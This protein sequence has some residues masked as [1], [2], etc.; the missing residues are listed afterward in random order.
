MICISQR[1][2][3]TLKSSRGDNHPTTN[4]SRSRSRPNIHGIRRSLDHSLGRSLDSLC[5]RR[6]LFWPL[7]RRARV[8]RFRCRRRR[9]SPS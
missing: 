9:T 4:S 7:V 5:S 6:N 1:N 2:R 3:K 8:L